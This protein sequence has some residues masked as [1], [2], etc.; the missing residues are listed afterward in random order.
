VSHIVPIYEGSVL[1]HAVQRLD[2]AG[3]DITQY[4]AVVSSTSVKIC[5]P[6]QLSLNVIPLNKVLIVSSVRMYTGVLWFSR[7]SAT[8]SIDL[9][10]V[11]LQIANFYGFF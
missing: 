7:R 5:H 1:P 11:T 9:F 8:A 6:V 4:L 2:L 3:R 10:V